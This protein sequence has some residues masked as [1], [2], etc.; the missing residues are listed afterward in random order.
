[1]KLV[2]TLRCKVALQPLLVGCITVFQDDRIVEA[3]R[4]PM[5]PKDFGRQSRFHE[6]KIL[7]KAF[8]E[9]FSDEK[10]KAALMSP[11]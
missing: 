5:N 8:P 4:K 11:F 1:M 7:D 10:I 2:G 6:V 3:V 9:P